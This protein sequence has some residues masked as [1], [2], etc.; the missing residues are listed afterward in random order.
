MREERSTEKLQEKQSKETI[1][2]GAVQRDATLWDEAWSTQWDHHYKEAEK[3]V[4]P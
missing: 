3:E 1:P 2:W 4:L